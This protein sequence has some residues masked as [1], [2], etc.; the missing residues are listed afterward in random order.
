[1]RDFISSAILELDNDELA[2]KYFRKYHEKM[3]KN[4]NIN[5]L[6]IYT[7]LQFLNTKKSSNK[8]LNQLDKFVL[9]SNLDSPINQTFKLE[10]SIEERFSLGLSYMQEFTEEVE[11]KFNKTALYL[12]KVIESSTL[13]DISQLYLNLRKDFIVRFKKGFLSLN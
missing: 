11:S 3:M 6:W 10:K 2:I 5:E 4:N 8:N 13:S 12:S 1:M 7:F 9:I